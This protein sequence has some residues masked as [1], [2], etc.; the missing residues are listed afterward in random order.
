MLYPIRGAKSFHSGKTK[1]FKSVGVQAKNPLTLVIQLEQ[2]TPYF[3][4][5]LTHNTW[6]PIHPQTI[7]THGSPTDRL[8]P[9]TQPKNFVGN[10]PLPLASL[11][12]ESPINS[13]QKIRIIT[14]L[15]PSN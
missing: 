8:A 6:W 12:T 7:L 15:I 13:Q 5:L 14:K 2:A 11:E 9:W 4:S 10:G 1:Q 3:L